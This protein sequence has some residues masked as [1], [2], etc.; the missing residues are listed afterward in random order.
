M[1]PGRRHGREEGARAGEVV[2]RVS[3]DQARHG[4]EEARD[5]EAVARDSFAVAQNIERY[6]RR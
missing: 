4:E 1:I 2:A 5:G 6:S 3:F